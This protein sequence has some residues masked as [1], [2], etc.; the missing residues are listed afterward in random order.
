MFYLFDMKIPASEVKTI[1]IFRALQLGDL[2]CAIPAIRA[3][4]NAYPNAEITLTGL[5]W[6]KSL[7]ER[8]PHY[9]DDF[10]WFPGFPG[11]PEQEIN[12]EAFTQFLSEVQ[13]REFDLVLQMQGNGSVVNPMVEIFGANYTAGFFKPDH[14]YPPNGLFLEYPDQGSEI[15]RH[16]ALMNFLG[17]E[18]QGNDLEFPLTAQD[19]ADFNQANLNLK[20]K[21]YVCIHPG[22]RGDWRQWPTEYFAKLA[23]YA[24]EQGFEAVITGTKDE[25]KIVAEVVNKMNQVPTL[26]AGKTTLGAIGFLIK[27]AFALISNC[28]GVSHL[29]SAF[30]TPSIVISMDGEPERWAPLNREIHRVFDWTVNPDLDQVFKETRELFQHKDENVNIKN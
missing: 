13:N 9:I 20:P 25:M 12:P 4:R 1:I 15:E 27:N 2:L 7:I 26:A 21:Q 8:F 29:A 3:L 22:S 28:T 5:A 11:L 6:A 23:D 19:E 24:I 18:S 17:I 16:L 10:I 30:K 14:Y